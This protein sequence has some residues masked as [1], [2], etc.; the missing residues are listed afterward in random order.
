[1]TALGIG[2]T[3]GEIRTIGVSEVMGNPC[4]PSFPSHSVPLTS[5]MSH[6]DFGEREREKER[7]DESGSESLALLPLSRMDGRPH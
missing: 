2:G 1:M 7:P 5:P 6:S 4:R 3:Y